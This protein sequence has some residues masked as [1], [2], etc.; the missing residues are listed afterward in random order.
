MQP[1]CVVINSTP[2]KQKLE[3]LDVTD[4]RS[5]DATCCRCSEYM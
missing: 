1:N 3:V 5:N 2:G 4:V